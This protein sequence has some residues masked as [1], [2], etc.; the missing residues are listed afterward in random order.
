MRVH[1]KVLRLKY[2]FFLKILDQNADHTF[3]IL[4]KDAQVY[5]T[6]HDNH[7][8]D[9]ITTNESM[10]CFT[11]KLVILDQTVEFCTCQILYSITVLRSQ[12]YMG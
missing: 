12:R 3:K 2:I 10:A 4:M 1:D 8:N 9:T 11:A 5:K 6:N 7:S